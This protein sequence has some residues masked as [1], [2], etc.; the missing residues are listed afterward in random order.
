MHVHRLQPPAQLLS[1]LLQHFLLLRVIVPLLSFDA[2]FAGFLLRRDE[3]LPDTWRDT[4][5]KKS[6]NAAFVQRPFTAKIT[7]VNM[8]AY[9]DN[10][11]INLFD[12]LLLLMLKE[13]HPEVKELEGRELLF[14][15]LDLV[16]L[17]Q[18]PLLSVNA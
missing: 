6:S 11:T 17:R 8:N 10:R 14:Q 18:P 3:I 2:T 1:V 5:L 16:E 7:Y 9:M 13:L 4:R 12:D 15:Q